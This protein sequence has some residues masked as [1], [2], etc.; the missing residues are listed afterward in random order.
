M[1]FIEVG[2]RSSGC[3]FTHGLNTSTI[4]T[5]DLQRQHCHHLRQLT[6]HLSAVPWQPLFSALTHCPLAALSITS[7][8]RATVTLTE[9]M[10][11]DMLTNFPGLTSLEDE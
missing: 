5:L 9:T 11:M 4:T 1:L 6:L 2:C 3:K 10:A 7:Y 8:E